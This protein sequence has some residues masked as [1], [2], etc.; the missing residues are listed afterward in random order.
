MTDSQWNNNHLY[1][2]ISIKCISNDEFCSVDSY[3]IIHG[4][5][6]LELNEPLISEYISD[7]TTLDLGCRDNE[8]VKISHE[9]KFDINLNSFCKAKTFIQCMLNTFI[10]FL[11]LV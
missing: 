1:P 2:I 4:W 8:T 5:S 11:F 9:F 6:I 3:G 10:L 7:S